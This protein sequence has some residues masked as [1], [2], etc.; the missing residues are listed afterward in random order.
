ML[1]VTATCPACRGA[2][3]TAEGVQV[4]MDEILFHPDCAPRCL[5]CGRRMRS[6]DEE[7]WF[8]DAQVVSV[9]YGYS[10]RPVASW[11][12]EC[13]DSALRDEPAAL[14]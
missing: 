10:L 9:R 4:G 6:G 14:D 1:E 5:T 3:M 8:L 11:C 13:W 2:L 12:P 7:R